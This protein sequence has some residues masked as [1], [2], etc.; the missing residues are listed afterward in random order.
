MY[1]SILVPVDLAEAPLATPAINAAVTFAKSTGGHVRLIYVRSLMPVTYMEFVPADF[2]S[3]QQADAQKKLD[4]VAL[5]VDLP[6]EQVSTKVVL[7]SVHTETLREAESWG[8][9]LV[10][11]W[12]HKPGFASYLLGSNAATIVRHSKCS[13]LVVR[14]HIDKVA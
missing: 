4:S 6:R 2:D 9:D 7:G 12:S 8:A 10:V 11:V 5:M 14:D 3:E 13:V 1:K